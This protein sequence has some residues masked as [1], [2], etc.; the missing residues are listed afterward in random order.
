MPSNPSISLSDT[1]QNWPT[2]ISGKRSP[3]GSRGSVDRCSAPPREN[4]SDSSA[5]GPP[6]VKVGPDPRRAASAASKPGAGAEG[7]DDRA[8]GPLG[9]L[10]SSQQ[11]ARRDRRDARWLVRSS[12]RRVTSSKALR[13]CGACRVGG[14]STVSVRWTEGDSAGFSGL[15]SCGSVWTCPVCA[16][17]IAARRQSDIGDALTSWTRDGHGVVFVTLTVRHGRGQSLAEVWD[18]V[19]RAWASVHSTASWRGGARTVGDVHRFGIEGFIKVIEVTHGE[20]GWHVHAHVAVL[21]DVVLC[22]D[23]ADRLGARMF[24][25]WA[26]GAV[27]AGLAAPAPAHGVDVQVV[28]GE[29]AAEAVA[30]YLSKAGVGGVSAELMGGAGATKYAKG[31]NRTLWDVAASIHSAVEHGVQPSTSDLAIWREWEF[32]SSRRRQIAW[33]KGLRERL[34]VS[35]VDDVEIAAAEAGG[36]LVAHVSDRGWARLRRDTRGQLDLLRV[37]EREPTPESAAEAADRW[38]SRNGVE[39]LDR[40]V[41][42]VGHRRFHE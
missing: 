26:N 23:S 11:H 42:R 27:R 12:L 28:G 10:G 5:A 21:T 30:K 6:A 8:G 40:V 20:N 25:R 7:G 38:L 4:V 22:P 2:T 9:Q 41:L 36:Y 37:V 3:K 13:A 39:Y 24:G 1:G 15:Q 33:S 29:D 32:G 17:K 16:A 18:G 35:E 34:G 19:S 14:A 31:G